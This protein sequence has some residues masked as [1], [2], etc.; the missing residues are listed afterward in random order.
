MSSGR[1]MV[2]I[3]AILLAGTATLS[4]VVGIGLVQQCEDSCGGSS[5]GGTS[6]GGGGSGG[7]SATGSSG[8]GGKPQ[9]QT[10]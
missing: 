6:S 7:R 4:G 9:P 2:A 5:G 8:E 10:R 3:A 1:T